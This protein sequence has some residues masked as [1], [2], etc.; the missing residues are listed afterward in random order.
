[1]SYVVQE[2]CRCKWLTAYRHLPLKLE[3]SLLILHLSRIFSENTLNLQRNC[4]YI[5]LYSAASD[6]LLGDVF[7]EESYSVRFFVSFI[8]F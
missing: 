2:S 7:A 5:M 1:M 8:S 3:A 4:S 6:E